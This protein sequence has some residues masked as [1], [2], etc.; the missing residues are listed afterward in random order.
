MEWLTLCNY[1][2][3]LILICMMIYFFVKLN[4]L[5][6]LIYEKVDETNKS[7]SD[8]IKD[9][10]NDI[11]SKFNDVITLNKLKVKEL[12]VEK[13][14]NINGKL[15][16][17]NIEGHILSNPDNYTALW[18]KNPLAVEGSITTGY[19]NNSKNVSV[20]DD[21]PT[22][23]IDEIKTKNID[24]I[25]LTSDKTITNKLTIINDYD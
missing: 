20:H 2:L 19:F 18:I 4:R 11:Q 21:Y 6:I 14:A 24:T 10:D 3:F 8:K 15:K 12:L 17:Y 5:N 9:L 13:D 7:R 1:L 25:K 22:L 23:H 16:A